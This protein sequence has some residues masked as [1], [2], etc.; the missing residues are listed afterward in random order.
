MNIVYEGVLWCMYIGY[1][2]VC[3]LNTEGAARGCLNCITTETEVYN[4]VIP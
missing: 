2:H 1:I 3:N 4:C